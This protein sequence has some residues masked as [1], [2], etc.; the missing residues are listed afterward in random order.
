M[1]EVA[2]E[3]IDLDAVIARCDRVEPLERPVG[4]AVIHEHDAAG[5]PRQPLEH[6][7]NLTIERLDASGL[8]KAGHN[9]RQ[10]RANGRIGHR[11][12]R[13]PYRHEDRH[14]KYA[15]HANVKEQIDGWYYGAPDV[16]IIGT[17]DRSFATEFLRLVLSRRG[18]RPPRDLPSFPEPVGMAAAVSPGL[19]AAGQLLRL[20]RARV[21]GPADAALSGLAEG[22]R[23][24]WAQPLHGRAGSADDPSTRG[25]RAAEPPA[26]RA[27][28]SWP[29]AGSH[30][31]FVRTWSRSLAGRH[32]HHHAAR[33]ADRDVL[34][35]AHRT[36]SA[37]WLRDN[38][39]RAAH[40]VVEGRGH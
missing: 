32:R 35:P 26:C 19:S 27:R 13:S 18:R 16:A 3:R 9:D 28:T 17:N 22:D 12:R 14:R 33:V 4:T 30:N 40:Q 21:H 38:R 1:T 8:V 11:H 31:S 5:D 36:Q 15:E 39:Y 7:A 29:T 2:R 34:H 20:C 37:V 24:H 23:K 25:H 6:R 10:R